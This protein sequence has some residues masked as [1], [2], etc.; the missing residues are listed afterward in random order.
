MDNNR[1]RYSELNLIEKINTPEI[2]LE[3]EIELEIEQ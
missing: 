2:D 1:N 3:E